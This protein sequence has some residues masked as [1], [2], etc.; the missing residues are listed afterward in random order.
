MESLSAFP[1]F[2]KA[3]IRMLRLRMLKKK[4]LRIKSQFIHSIYVFDFNIQ[5]LDSYMIQ[6]QLKFYINNLA[7]IYFHYIP[8]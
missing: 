3:F 7:N 6:Q 2:H 8:I 5:L 4:K 1:F